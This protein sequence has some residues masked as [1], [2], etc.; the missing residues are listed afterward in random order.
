VGCYTTTRMETFREL[1]AI[2]ANS[3]A[4]RS[5]EHFRDTLESLSVSQRLILRSEGWTSTVISRTVAV[6]PFRLEIYLACGFGYPHAKALVDQ[7]I[8]MDNPDVLDVLLSDTVMRPAIL[9]R[10]SLLDI[11]RIAEKR[12]RA[13][14]LVRPDVHIETDDF[15]MMVPYL[16]VE[17][18]RDIIKHPRLWHLRRAM[19]DPIE[20]AEKLIQTVCDERDMSS[21]TYDAIKR[22]C[23]YDR[24]QILQSILG[25]I[26]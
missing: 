26:A 2:I 15:M 4:S 12:I 13:Y 7:A 9:Y 18:M 8:A 10:M 11:L 23:K 3:M 20:W 5:L 24:Y 6:C 19:P 17:A 22:V 1:K 14:L 25:E 21:Y 16:T